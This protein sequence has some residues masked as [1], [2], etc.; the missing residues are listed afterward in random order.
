MGMTP[1]WFEKAKLGIFIHWGIYAVQGTKESWA[2]AYPS[3]S[4]VDYMKQLDGFTA[5]NYDPTYWA[6]LFKKAGAKYA[7]LT[8]KHHDG[9]A[10]WDTKC[11]DLSVVKRTPAGRDLVTPYCKAMREAGIKVG[12]YYSHTD[13]SMDEHL[14]VL[15]DRT[16]DEI[17]EM[18][19]KKT[20]FVEMW[21]EVKNRTFEQANRSEDHVR[22]WETF[23]DF[24]FRQLH[25]VVHNF[26]PLDVFWGDGMFEMKG[27]D[28]Q[29]K[30]AHDMIKAANP[31]TVISRLPEYSDVETPEVRIPCSRP[32][33]GVWEYCTPINGSWGYRPSD[34]NYKSPLQVMRLF[35]D[36][37]SLGGNMLL[38]IGPREDGTIDER[39]E[40]VLLRIGDFIR[41]N[42]EAI[43]ESEQG[44]DR[45]FY[46]GGS[47]FSRDRKR[48]YLFVH[49][50]PREGIMVKGVDTPYT[51]AS[52][53]SSGQELR[54]QEF[55]DGKYGCF[56]IHMTPDMVDPAMPTVVKVEFAE[57]CVP[58]DKWGMLWENEAAQAKE[59]S[60]LRN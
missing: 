49:E 21:S 53:L 43:Y 6:E 54:I 14:S 5:K 32:S 17:R 39:Q 9:V 30:R 16:K 28:W 19:Q 56:W 33:A 34:N 26:G 18:R 25:E 23:M 41:K 52:I 31:D 40:E 24:Y 46:G 47:V 8:A 7:V 3:M 11:N 36:I 2:F 59:P 37:L 13:W 29:K 60:I 12:F 4:Y 42:E 45:R 58:V 50:I 10:L 44:L 20:A 38:D 51:K 48:L 55:F 22:S 15:C 35:C 27:F 1:E 57:P